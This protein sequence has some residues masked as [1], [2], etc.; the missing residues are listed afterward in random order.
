MKAIRMTRR[1]PEENTY[2]QSQTQD[3]NKWWNTNMHMNGIKKKI[4][5]NKHNKI[6]YFGDFNRQ[7]IYLIIKR[8]H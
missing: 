5:K 1:G 3:R 4:D 2:F 8:E 6:C 7:H